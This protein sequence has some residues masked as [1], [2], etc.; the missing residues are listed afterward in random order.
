MV[1]ELQNNDFNTHLCMVML[2]P[3]LLINTELKAAAGQTILT[4]VLPN[5]IKDIK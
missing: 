1:S 2:D 3:P 5:S 4:E